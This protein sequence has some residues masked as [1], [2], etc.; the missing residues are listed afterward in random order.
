MIAG[1]KPH[2]S[3]FLTADPHR[4]HAAAHSHHPWPDVTFE[5][6]QQAWLDAAGLQD[7]KWDHVFGEVL[8]EAQRHVAA[9][10]RLP[11]PSTVAFAPNTRE[12]VARIVS[13]LRSPARV[14]TTDAEFHSFARQVA[15]WEE[16]GS[17]VVDRIASAPLESFP[18]RFLAA[19]ARGGH[20]LVF[21]S[22]VLFDSGLVVTDAA[23]IVR[24]VPDDDTFV[25]VDGYHGFMAVPTDFS[26]VA[27]RA[28]YTAGGY[29]YAMAGEG[30]CFLHCPPGYGPRPVDTGWFA[31]FGDL[32]ARPAGTVGY[33]GDGGRFLGATFDP[34]ALYRFNAVQRWLGELGLSVADIHAHVRDLQQQFLEHVGDAVPPPDAQPSGHFFSFRMGDADA[35]YRRLHDRGVITDFRGDRLRVGLGLYHDTADVRRLASSLTAAV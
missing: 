6:H 1:Y 4:L 30:A 35:T 23:E 33:P 15:R 34:S 22:Q 32:V 24:S 20:D 10:L 19:A 2:F 21:F 26:T 27:D 11:D 3:R 17:V 13:C 12:L 14:L 29:K 7:D 5:A 28:F 18:E 9:Q 16:A 31:G 8:P 25:V